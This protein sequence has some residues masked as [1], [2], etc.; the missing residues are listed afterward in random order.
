[1]DMMIV[2]HM[3]TQGEKDL[4]IT[5]RLP[6]IGRLTIFQVEN[7]LAYSTAKT[8]RRGF[9]LADYYSVKYRRSKLEVSIGYLNLM[10]GLFVGIFHGL[11]RI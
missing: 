11:S 6:D 10:I 9:R 3:N 2:W 7:V 4:Y 8:G 1:M 5:N